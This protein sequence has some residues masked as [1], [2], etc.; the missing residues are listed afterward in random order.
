[1][2]SKAALKAFFK[3]FDLSLQ[4]YIFLPLIKGWDDRV[5]DGKSFEWRL[6]KYVKARLIQF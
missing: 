3:V 2:K 5:P 1:M 4:A 6:I